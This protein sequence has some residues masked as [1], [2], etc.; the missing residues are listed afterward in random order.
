MELLRSHIA[1]GRPLHPFRGG[2]GNHGR[3]SYVAEG[4]FHDWPA[5]RPNP[6]EPK[7]YWT[8][9]LV[10]WVNL[11]GFV[12]LCDKDGKKPWIPAERLRE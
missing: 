12:S 2:G 6:V 1:D 9:I 11:C 10:S 5:P 8:D 3:V 7:E 4:Q